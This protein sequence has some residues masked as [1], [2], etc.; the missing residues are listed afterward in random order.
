[1]V[2]CDTA[3]RGRERDHSIKSDARELKQKSFQTGSFLL[4]HSFHYNAVTSYPI[5]A[6]H[7]LLRYSNMALIVFYDSSSRWHD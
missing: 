5:M 6:D 2:Y 7:I 4:K 1:M 3:E